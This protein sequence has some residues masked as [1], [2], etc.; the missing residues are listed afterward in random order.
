MHELTCSSYLIHFIYLMYSNI[1]V[2]TVKPHICR[3]EKEIIRL[4][5][6]PTVTLRQVKSP[7]IPPYRLYGVYV[8]EAKL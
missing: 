8:G 1:L 4:K 5:I 3:R 6:Y 7:H 2:T